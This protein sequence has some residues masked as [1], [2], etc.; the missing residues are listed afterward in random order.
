MAVI[1]PFRAWRYNDE[2]TQNIGD[3]LSPPFDVVSP[4]QR[5]ALYQNPLN[6]I[7][8][9]VPSGSHPAQQAAETLE[10]W[11]QEGII[12]QDEVPGIYVYYQYFR[13]PGDPK[14]YCRKGFICMIEASFWEENVVLRHEDTIPSSV[15]DRIQ[16]LE[17][18]QLNASPTHG[19]YTDPEHHLEA[20]MDSSME[21][22]LYEAEDFQG[23]R[24]VLS[25]IREEDKIQYFLS[26][27]AEKQIILADGHH[28]Y[29]SSLVYRRKMMQNNPHHHGKEGYNFHLMYLTNTE[30]ED[31]K[32][33]PTHRLVKKTP[34]MDTDTLLKKCAQYFEIKPQENNCDIPEVIAGKP[35]TF[36]LLLQ[37]ACFKLRLKPEVHQKLDLPVSE[38]LKKL[39]VVVLH[40]FFLEKVLGVAWQEQRSSEQIAYERSFASCLYEVTTT[41]EA[42]MALITN[43]VSIAQIKE[44]CYGGHL[45]PQKSTYFYPKVIC[46]FLF[47]SIHEKEF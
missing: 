44:I 19:L 11:K 13:L 29:E 6:S 1:R 23:V 28:R 25:V 15:N 5:A 43:G 39:D 21:K 36:G 17:A 26:L 18:T 22:V 12:R 16:L 40:Y 30:S 31:L 20:L 4:K 2:L 24:D 35:W 45:L 38:A 3:Q 8:L 33:L 37:D 9:S 42:Q 34:A 10:K 32:V 47:G 14:E 46:G 27:L 7:H 41:H